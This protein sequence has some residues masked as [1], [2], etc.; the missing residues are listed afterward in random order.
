VLTSGAG[1]MRR[2]LDLLPIASDMALVERQDG[3]WKQRALLHFTQ[4]GVRLIVNRSRVLRFEK[5]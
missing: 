4:A 2:E 5:V 3:P 1:P